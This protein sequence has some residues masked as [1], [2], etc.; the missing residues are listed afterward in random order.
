MSHLMSWECGGG[1]EV[2]ADGGGFN[3]FL[4][5]MTFVQNLTND[6]LEQKDLGQRAVSLRR[7]RVMGDIK[8]TVQ[9]SGH[10]SAPFIPQQWGPAV[11][12]EGFDQ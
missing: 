7:G 8:Q 9:V 10:T 11:D 6:S 12:F 3:D 1:A 2:N 4:G 5:E